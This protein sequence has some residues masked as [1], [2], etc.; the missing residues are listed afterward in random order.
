MSTANYTA[1]YVQVLSTLDVQHSYDMKMMFNR[2]V[3]IG[4]ESELTLSET[5]FKNNICVKS[6]RQ[7][8]SQSKFPSEESLI[9]LFK[10]KNYLT[11]FRGI[12]AAAE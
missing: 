9:F 4:Y 8:A 3:Y 2:E 5:G 6:N 1:I 11:F 7:W 10:H 12:I